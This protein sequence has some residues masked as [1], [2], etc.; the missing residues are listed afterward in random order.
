M[1]ARIKR[2]QVSPGVLFSI[3]Q[4]GTGWTVETGIP[5]GA[6]FRGATLDPFTQILHIFVEH[7]SFAEVDLES[8]VSPSLETLFKKLK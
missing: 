7:P 6:T 5:E 1:K 4:T 3:M 2:M 8:E